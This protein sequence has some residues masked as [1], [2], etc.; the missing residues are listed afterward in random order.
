MFFLSVMGDIGPTKSTT[1][2]SKGVS[3]R[4]IC[5]NGTLVTFPFGKVLRQRSHDK[6]CYFTSCC[7]P[8]QKK[9]ERILSLVFFIH[10]CPPIIDSW[11]KFRQ[12]FD[13]TLVLPIAFQFYLDL[14]LHLEITCTVN[15]F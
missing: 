9:C 15:H 7:K 13:M 3:I 5:S 10:K 2:L 14:S 12:Y 6:Q 8:G 4:G 1:T 11:A